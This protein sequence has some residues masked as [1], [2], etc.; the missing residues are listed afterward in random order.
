MDGQTASTVIPALTAWVD[1]VADVIAGKT[2]PGRAVTLDLTQPRRTDR[3]T[4]NTAQYVVSA[5]GDGSFTTGPGVVDFDGSTQETT[6]NTRSSRPRS[7]RRR[8]T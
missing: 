5:G 1:P 6:T 4:G 3:C 2:E 7:S 8:R